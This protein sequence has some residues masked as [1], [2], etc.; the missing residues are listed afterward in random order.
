MYNPWKIIK[1]WDVSLRDEQLGDNDAYFT[2]SPFVEYKTNGGFWILFQTEHN[3]ISL[4][5]D[6]VQTYDNPPFSDEDYDI[7]EVD[8]DYED[9]YIEGMET[10]L[11]VGERLVEVIQEEKRFRLIFDD[12]EMFLV[13]EESDRFWY[14]ENAE[15]VPISA[16]NRHI[17]RKCACGG[18]G[19]LMIDFVSDFYIRC[20]KC[21]K[22]TWAT[23]EVKSVIDD[24]NEGETETEIELSR[25]R[26]MAL[27]D[28][29]VNYIALD[30]HSICYDDN[31]WDSSSLIISIGNSLFKLESQR[32]GDDKY[33]FEYHE[34]SDYNKSMWPN[35]VVPTSEQGI[36][37]VCFEEEPDSFKVM[38]LV[39]G[40]RPILLTV[41]ESGITIGVSHWGTDGQDI[42]FENNILING[43]QK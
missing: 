20:N 31:M 14:E 39:D 7:C 2:V 36:R 13:P 29:D 28:N 30:E 5:K 16:F 18:Q 35:L 21:H 10:T 22:S 42:E 17:K 6:G 32:I 23:Y 37:F 4:G 11:F 9:D 25:E 34:L 1:V 27:L 33:D 3:Y 12:F 38:R 24:W 26:F 8:G 43:K 41:D 19:E 40:I 15:D